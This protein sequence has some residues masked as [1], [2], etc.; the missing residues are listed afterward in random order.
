MIQVHRKAHLIE[1]GM[2]EKE[3]CSEVF[4]DVAQVLVRGE[5]F[6]LDELLSQEVDI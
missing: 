6:D 1:Y 4:S 3:V 2:G 5:T